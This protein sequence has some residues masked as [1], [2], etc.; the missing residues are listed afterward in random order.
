M[1][2]NNRKPTTVFTLAILLTQSSCAL[3][4]PKSAEEEALEND[5]VA[6]AAY[7]V[8]QGSDRSPASWGQVA[9]QDGTDDSG[10]SAPIPT[11][12]NL[13]LGMSM[14]RVRSLWGNPQDVETAGDPSQGNQRWIYSEG[15]KSRY[16]LASNRVIYFE[17]GRVAGWES[18]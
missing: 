12:K 11:Y 9:S 8:R 6:R 13:I 4:S 5:P 7:E 15:I 1:I 14:P 18:N 10:N 3:L 16:G 2:Q 17:D